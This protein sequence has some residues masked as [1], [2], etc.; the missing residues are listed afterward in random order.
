MRGLWLAFALCGLTAGPMGAQTIAEARLA[1]PTTRYDHGVLGDAIEYG[2][3]H[4][5]PATGAALRV[6]LPETRV[7]EDVEARVIRLEPGL[8]AVLV[9]ETDLALGASLAL[10][11]AKGDK[12]AATPFF[13][14]PNRWYAPVGAA[15]F[16]GDGTVEI[17]FVDR[18]HLQK[19]LVFVRLN[20]ARL[21]EVAR[22]PGLTNHRIGDSTITSGI[23]DCGQGAEVIAP[24]A[25]WQNLMA[26]TTKG[27]QVIGPFG[28]KAL[29]DALAC[30]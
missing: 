29:Q 9:V 23:R 10:Y 7:F 1:E 17:A 21:E 12:I 30:R 19:D 4:L 6:R 27:A 13:G 2:A 20:G 28:A 26:A 15:D 14:Q 11:G 5:R 22:I 24:D 16:D 3:L 25:G 8:D 18:P